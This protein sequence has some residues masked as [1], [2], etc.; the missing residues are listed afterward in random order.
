[1][2]SNELMVQFGPAVRGNPNVFDQN[3]LYGGLSAGLSRSVRASLGCIWQVQQRPS[4]R[5]FDYAT[6]VW[7]VVTADNVLG[8]FRN[9][10]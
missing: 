5:E 8:R 4:G 9:K 7:G 1:V 2:V 10:R 6:V 3:R